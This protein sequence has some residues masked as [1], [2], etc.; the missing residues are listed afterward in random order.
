MSQ[1][2]KTQPRP[3]TFILALSLGVCG[4]LM[5]YLICSYFVFL[6]LGMEALQQLLTKGNTALFDEMRRWTIR[7][8][9]IL[10]HSLNSRQRI[11]LGTTGIRSIHVCFSGVCGTEVSLL[12]MIIEL[13]MSDPHVQRNPFPLQTFT[14]QC[15]A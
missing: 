10:R 3:D 15:L 1:F 6:G 14:M 11:H 9:C 5:Q 7:G 13:K 2:N 4:I 8:H 12:L